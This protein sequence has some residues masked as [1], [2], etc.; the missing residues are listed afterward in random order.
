M[1]DKTSNQEH[2]RFT[3]R[4]NKSLFETVKQNAFHNRRAI[5]KEMEYSLFR[6]YENLGL[7]KQD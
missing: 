1:F 3:L 2:V 7:I 4:I 5:G 6:Y